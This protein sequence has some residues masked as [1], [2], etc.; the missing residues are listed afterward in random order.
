VIVDDATTRAGL[1]RRLLELSGWRGQSGQSVAVA[2]RLFATVHDGDFPGAIVPR[3]V[4]GHFVYYPAAD[5]PLQWRRLAPL[6]KAAVGVTLTD[7]DGRTADP[8]EEDEFERVLAEAGLRFGRAQAQGDATVRQ[9]VAKSL[10]ALVE[11]VHRAQEIPQP[12]LRTTSSLL[13][14]FDLA[15]A[16]Q[17]RG[18]AFDVIARLRSDLRLEGINHLFLE[19]EAL[20]G[21]GAW[22]EIWGADFFPDVARAF[23]PPLV[24]TALLRATYWS[25]LDGRL[26]AGAIKDCLVAMEDDVLP[27]WGSLGESHPIDRSPD[28][29]LP[30][31]AAAVVQGKSS[32]LVDAEL[33]ASGW[34]PHQAAALEQ[35]LAALGDRGH[36]P[37]EP[38]AAPAVSERDQLRADLISASLSSNSTQLAGVRA[39]FAAL[40]PDLL[41]DVIAHPVARQAWNL[42]ANYETSPEISTWLEWAARLPDLDVTQARTWAREAMVEA[43]V[44]KVLDCGPVVDQFTRALVEAASKADETTVSVL[45]IVLD[46]LMRDPE[47]PRIEFASLYRDMLDILLLASETS[48]V[49]VAGVG[50]LCSAI[51]ALGMSQ[52]AYASLCRDLGDWVG[53]ATSISTVDPLCDIAELTIVHLSPDQAARSTLWGS[54]LAALRPLGRRLD[55]VQLAV[56]RAIDEVISGGELAAGIE[57]A[58][59]SDDEPTGNASVHGRVA[60]YTLVESVARRVKQTLEATCPQVKVEYATDAVGSDRLLALAREADVFA[61]DWS[62]AKH[63]ATDFIRDNRRGRSVLFTTGSGSTAIAREILD[64]LRTSDRGS[65]A[66]A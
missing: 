31:L 17:D 25:Q 35:F 62:R 23:R 7:F 18:S 4:H 66:A 48:S 55:P 54:L 2:E 59:A 37:I 28:V 26:A 15:L 9:R 29:V 49:V 61:I 64:A 10:E 11:C 58:D 42:L 40:D 19:V 51:L 63:A 53:S 16:L 3:F 30:L 50:R 60:L 27:R 12:S 45:P 14:D 43:P 21:T 6:V 24:T 5:T 32:T 36:A 65:S 56:V 39:R 38:P 44:E 52:A 20:A 46:W 34:E 41:R 47:W 13:R 33:K 1:S 8:H 57:P 22:T